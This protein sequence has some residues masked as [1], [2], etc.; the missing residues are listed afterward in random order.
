MPSCVDFSFASS[1]GAVD[2][3]PSL[4]KVQSCGHSTCTCACTE[5]EG[6]SRGHVCYVFDP[7]SQCVYVLPVL[8]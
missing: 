5:L 1:T 8:A 7:G 4:C 3:R 6:L 2:D